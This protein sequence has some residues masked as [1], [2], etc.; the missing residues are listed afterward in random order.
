MATYQHHF[1]LLLLG[2]AMDSAKN[3]RLYQILKPREGW[4]FGVTA[5]TCIKC[6]LLEEW[7][8]PGSKSWP[9]SV[10]DAPVLVSRTGCLYLRSHLYPHSVYPFFLCASHKHM[11]DAL[12][13][14][15]A[16]SPV[17]RTKEGP[18]S[19]VWPQCLWWQ[20]SAVSIHGRC[21]VLENHI[22]TLFHFSQNRQIT[23]LLFLSTGKGN[24]PGF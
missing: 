24:W 16:A 22:I 18:L 6:L 12:V 7:D 10:Q 9:C 17:S 4:E 5:L 2:T 20:R 23:N 1:F 19:L 3:P 14:T 11:G 8:C 21:Q 13:I 15:T